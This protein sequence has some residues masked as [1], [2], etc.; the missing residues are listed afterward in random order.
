[1]DNLRVDTWPFRPEFVESLVRAG[2]HQLKS[3]PGSFNQPDGCGDVGAADA[4]YLKL[5]SDDCCAGVDV[6]AVGT[7][8]SADCHNPRPVLRASAT[9]PETT[10]H[11]IPP[12]RAPGGS[13]PAAS[14]LSG[15][16]RAGEQSVLEGVLGKLLFAARALAES[17]ID[18]ALQV[19]CQIA[20][21][22]CLECASYG[23][24]SGPVQHKPL[25]KAGR[26][27]ELLDQICGEGGAR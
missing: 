20:P 26:V 11:K 25:C 24:N 15:E 3:D 17:R 7:V 4:P 8:H 27:L 5:A 18:A 16:G 22:F 6:P 2:A 13:T 10:S 14:L 21:A 23:K 9:L 12:R 19:G 1:M